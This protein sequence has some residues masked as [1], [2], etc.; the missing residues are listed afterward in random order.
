MRT[1]HGAPSNCRRLEPMSISPSQQ[2]RAFSGERRNSLNGLPGLSCSQYSNSGLRKISTHFLAAAY[3]LATSSGSR[4]TIAARS[5]LFHRTFLN[6]APSDPASSTGY[7][8][9]V[10]NLTF[11]F[12]LACPRILTRHRVEYA[13]GDSRRSVEATLKPSTRRED[14]PEPSVCERRWKV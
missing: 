6:I 10:R 7:A 12:P 13:S 9:S 3:H 8:V 11:E 5:S 1:F 14:P 2:S 4:A